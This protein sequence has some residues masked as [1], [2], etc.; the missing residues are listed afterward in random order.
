MTVGKD[1]LNEPLPASTVKFPSPLYG[2]TPPDAVTLATV[3]L[4]KQLI[5]AA[6]VTGNNGVGAG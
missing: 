5:L 4:P 2:A 1:T 6:T 3:V